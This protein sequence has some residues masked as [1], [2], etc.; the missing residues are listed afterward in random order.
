MRDR[1]TNR[2]KILTAAFVR[3][4]STP[5]RYGDGRG[6][7]GLYLRVWRTANGRIGRNWAQELRIDGKAT[8]VG[9][10]PVDLISLAT[11]RERARVNARSVLE[12][13]DPRKSVVHQLT[14][15]QAVDDAIESRSKGWG[16][17]KTE[18]DW[19]TVLGYAL[20][21]LG[22]KPIADITT[23]DVLAV[24]EPLWTKKAATGRKLRERM[25][26]I[27]EWAIAQGHRTDNPASKAI[28]K[29]LPR[30]TQ[31]T[32]HRKALP[33]A[34]VGAAIVVIRGTDAW[35]TTKLCLEFLALTVTRSGEAR[36]AR[37]DEMDLE[38][39]TWTIPAARMKKNRRE[40]RIPLTQA[41]LGVLEKARQWSDDSGLVFPSS[42]SGKPISTETLSRLLKRRGIGCV[43]HGFR[44]SFR[45]W[46][47]EC[48]DVPREI[49]E[50]ALAHVEGSATELAYRR[51]DYFEK[52]R[53]LMEE[54]ADYLGLNG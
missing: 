7:Y 2:L 27:M 3:T 40:H 39:A 38:A 10:G 18:R 29:A 24:V 50:H 33:F 52:R 23:A 44:S 53:T 41:A 14:F 11:A 35:P 4:I 15:A 51:T 32:E 42:K 25:G 8:N 21:S 16:D 46:A 36:G 28:V 19:R 12:G 47:A 6:S 1:E 45:D 37:W 20:P 43:P 31:R 13:V 26:V 49:A 9:L 30:Q 17:K 5:G 22:A 48:S 34:E 54:W